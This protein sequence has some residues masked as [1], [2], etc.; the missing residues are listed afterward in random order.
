MKIKAIWKQLKG[1]SWQYSTPGYAVH[2]RVENSNLK[3]ELWFWSAG[4]TAH[5]RPNPSDPPP[6]GYATSLEGAKRIIEILVK[7]TGT[8]TIDD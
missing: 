7:E 8:L 3:P 1:G 5:C 6:R 2:G 4:T